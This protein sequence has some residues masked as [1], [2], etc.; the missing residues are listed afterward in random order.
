MAY[1]NKAYSG[2]SIM[3]AISVWGCTA[4]PV[5][6]S[7]DPAVAKTKDTLPRPE[8]LSTTDVISIQNQTINHNRTL[9]SVSQGTYTYYMGGILTA[10]FKESSKTLVVTPEDTADVASCEFSS[11]GVLNLENAPQNK[12]ETTIKNCNALMKALENSL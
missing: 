10:V 7:T 5:S 3:L 12:S 11:E 9:Y 2:L 1:I 6:S 8:P 4:Q